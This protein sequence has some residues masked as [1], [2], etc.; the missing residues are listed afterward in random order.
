MNKIPAKTLLASAILA[1]TGGHALAQSDNLGL[2]EIIVTAQKREQS[3]QD[4]PIAVSA[5]D[6][7]TIERQR[8]S[9][10]TDIDL[11]AP[12]VEIIDTPTNTTAAT[13][14][15][16]GASAINPAI[17]WENSVGIYVDGVFIGKNLGA[18]FDVAELE[19]VE[20]L[21][22]PQGTLYGKNTIGGAVN[23]ITRKPSGE[24]G[25]RLTGEFGNEGYWAARGSID[26]GEWEGL[27]ATVTLYKEERDGF[28]DNVADPFG[29][30]LAGPPSSDEFQDSDEKA[31]RIALLWDLTDNVAASYTFDY[32]DQDILPRFGQLTQTSLNSYLSS[33]GLQDAYLTK[34]DERAEKGS[35]DWA[36]QEKAMSRG[37]ALDLSWSG[38]NV[39]L[40]S[41]TAY[42][43]LEFDDTIDIDGTPI[44]IFHSS[45]AV[46]Y[47]AFSQELQLTGSWS[48][49]DYVLGL[50]YFDESADVFNPITFFGAFGVPT[51]NNSYGLDNSSVAAYGQADWRPA[52]FNDSLTLSF[53]VRWTEE[54]KD[55]YID[56]PGFFAAETDDTFDNVSP[57]V[58]LSW[59]FSDDVSV[60]ARY[61]QGWKSG[62]FNGEASLEDRFLK[63]Y[64]DEEA[65]A[66]ELGMKSLLWNDRLQ[67]NA[68]LFYNDIEN[69]QLS[70]FE[71]AAAASLVANIPEFET[72]GGEL[73]M[74]AL[75]T[76]TFRVNLAYGYLDA[77][78]KKFPN[79]FTLFD[80]DDAGVPYAPE[81]TLTVG[82]DWTLAST[83]WGSWDLHV[84]ASY[85]DDY[86][87]F[88][89]PDQVATSQIDDRILLN[90]RLA[91]SEIPVSDDASLLIAL[92]GQNLT[93]EDYRINTIPFGGVDQRVDPNGGSG[94]GWT[95]SYF[96]APRTYGIELTYSF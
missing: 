59:A 86:V 12:N 71:G 50:Y 85:T 40:R 89:D 14:A 67:L 17:T 96:G 53:G 49:L 13:I 6:S 43:E 61:A 64:D 93:D 70:V 87:P 52:M 19:R 27:K 10:I 73:E 95:T 79:D 45:R 82:A 75:L 63:G 5:F 69:F 18:V 81:H 4:I 91:W 22:G 90:A 30:P 48:Q 94:V 41:I 66:Y 92:W 47:D 56:H 1:A 46:D 84:D 55:Q 39:T 2:E 44:D 26:T 8:I 29:I 28:A 15:I 7:A 57:T 68:A 74:V 37:H 60:Y 65:D 25:G 31:A 9:R 83:S 32:S 36:F 20:V 54:D 3:I 34:D 77:E 51:L 42:R 80:K 62:G 88:I 16:R 58:A 33:G 35:N 23:L 24:F 38:D 11:Y 72:M 21:R 76:D 78:Y